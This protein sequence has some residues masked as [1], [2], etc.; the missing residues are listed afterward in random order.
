MLINSNRLQDRM[1]QLS[2]IGKMGETGVRR[3][4]H[5]EEDREAVELV[6]SWMKE[7]GLETRID[8][9]GNLIG[10]LEG[11]HASESVLIIGSH[12]DSQPYGG[13]FDGTS[14]ALGAL[15]V[16]QTMQEQGIKPD[17]PL[18]IVCF[19]DEEGCRFNKGTFGSRGITGQL[20]EEELER[21][22]KDGIARK[23]ALKSFG[24]DPDNLQ[25]ST[26]KKGNIHTFLELQ[27]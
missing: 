21:K 10:R 4:A 8:N 25:G 13:R 9:F 12:I 3:L 7:A 11:L 23:D 14:G 27:D 18:D 26:Y 6:R 15:E 2:K 20:Q 17:R 22:D 5:S 16:A 24:C 19:A 1:E